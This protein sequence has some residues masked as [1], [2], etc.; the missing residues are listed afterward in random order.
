[1]TAR[2]RIAHVQTRSDPNGSLTRS[3]KVAIYLIDQIDPSNKCG[4]G[5]KNQA[6][7]RDRVSHV[8]FRVRVIASGISIGIALELL[9]LDKRIFAA[10]QDTGNKNR[11][12]SL[13]SN[14]HSS[15]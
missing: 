8:N 12:T 11:A 1:M 14:A 7:T 4:I 9:S 6:A 3:L 10:I 13:A 15:A 5:V 2:E